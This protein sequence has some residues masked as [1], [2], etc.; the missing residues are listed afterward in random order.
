MYAVKIKNLRRYFSGIPVLEN[1]S[2]EIPLKERHGLYGLPGSGKTTLIKIM[3]DLLNKDAGIIEIFGK[4]PVIYR[5][6]VLSKI[7]YIPEKPIYPP[8]YSVE[9]IMRLKAYFIKDMDKEDVNHVV[10]KILRE[11]DFREYRKIKI[12]KL[13]PDQIKTL[14][15]M[16][17]AIGNPAL[18]IID[19]IENLKLGNDI[20]EYLG[21][22][23][24]EDKTLFVTSKRIEVLE[25]ICEESSFLNDG[26]IIYRG[27]PGKL[28][29]MLMNS[30]V[31]IETSGLRREVLSKIKELDVSNEIEV[32]DK[33]IRIH[34]TFNYEIVEKIKNLLNKYKADIKRIRWLERRE[35]DES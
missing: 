24:Y 35:D 13:Y 29:E 1:I 16:L 32:Q 6:E 31:E 18:L 4:D 9:K 12:G 3:L 33:E 19:G 23:S 28:R 15:I 17:A 5:S 27:R 20:Q 14:S 30:R 11:F 8:Y 10:D 22:L 34:F 25:E 7:G 26:K 2:L 21:R